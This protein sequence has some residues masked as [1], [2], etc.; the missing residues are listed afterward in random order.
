[1][2][3]LIVALFDRSPRIPFHLPYSA[4]S[5]EGATVDWVWSV[6]QR[7]RE[8]GEGGQG[9][10]LPRL[11]PRTSRSGKY[12]I[13]PTYRR[14]LLDLRR[15]APAVRGEAA[16]TL[17]RRLPPEAH[18]WLESVLKRND[19]ASL[20]WCIQPGAA[21]WDVEAAMLKAALEWTEAQQIEGTTGTTPPP[22]G[23]SVP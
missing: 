14:L 8:R 19:L 3:A 2:A 13:N 11:R 16:A 18:K 9:L 6:Q 4:S 23:G 10:L 17:R 15:P 20:A 1:M 7:E 21:D 5:R 22:P 12:R